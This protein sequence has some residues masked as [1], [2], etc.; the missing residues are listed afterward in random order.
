MVD[1]GPVTVV[2]MASAPAPPM[3]PA[4]TTDLP[5]VPSSPEDEAPFR[6]PVFYEGADDSRTFCLGNFHHGER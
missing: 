6:T 4:D 5:Q 2:P 3:Q 1:A